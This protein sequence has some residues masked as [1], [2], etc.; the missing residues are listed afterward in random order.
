MVSVGWPEAAVDWLMGWMRD[1]SFSFAY[2]FFV[3]TVRISVVVVF[4]RRNQAC[5]AEGEFLLGFFLWITRAVGTTG[6][7]LS[8]S[9]AQISTMLSR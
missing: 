4:E 7:R 3:S 1:R 9:S 2:V 8:T 6:L 5:A